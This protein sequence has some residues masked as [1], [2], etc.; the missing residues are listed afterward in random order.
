MSVDGESVASLENPDSVVRAIVKVLDFLELLVLYSA[1]VLVRRFRTHMLAWWYVIAWTAG[2][3]TILGCG[4]LWTGNEFLTILF[5][6]LAGYRMFDIVRW[7]ADFLLDRRHWEVVSGERN[8]VFVV[9]NAAEVTLIGAIWL[10]ASGEFNH[11]GQAAYAAFLLVTQLDRPQ[12]VTTISRVVVVVTEV[13][14][15]VLLLGGLTVVIGV[16]QGKVKAT[17]EWRGEARDY[18]GG[19]LARKRA[20]EQN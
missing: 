9:M 18:P 19:W 11:P 17:D 5:V 14:S 20:K 15:L 8:L 10:F 16:V 1:L 12:A 3:A 4:E 7:W 13:A 6:V 2:L